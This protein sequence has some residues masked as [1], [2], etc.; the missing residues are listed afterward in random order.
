MFGSMSEYSDLIDTKMEFWFLEKLIDKLLKC[1]KNL[2]IFF[3]NKIV[4]ILILKKLILKKIE[5]F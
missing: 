4:F 2:K 3:K 5:K 1:I